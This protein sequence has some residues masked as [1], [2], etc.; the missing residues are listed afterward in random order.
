LPAVADAVRNVAGLE[1]K[2]ELVRSEQL[3]T[4]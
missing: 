3:P 4:L 1:K 2:F